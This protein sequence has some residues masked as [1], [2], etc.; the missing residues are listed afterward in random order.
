M[1]AF[2]KPYTKKEVKKMTFGKLLRVLVSDSIVDRDYNGHKGA[3][4]E[5]IVV[6]QELFRRI[7]APIPTPE[8]I[9]KII[10]PR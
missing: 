8:I 7:D 9:E 4:K 10:F 6:V 5:R 1:I 2:G 3:A